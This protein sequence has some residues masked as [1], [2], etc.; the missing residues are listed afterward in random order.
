MLSQDLQDGIASL[1]CSGPGHATFNN[2]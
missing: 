1:E 2:R